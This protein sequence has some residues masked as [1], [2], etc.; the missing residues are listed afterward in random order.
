MQMRLFA[1]WSQ[2]IYFKWGCRTSFE[3]R[4]TLQGEIMPDDARNNG[5]RSPEHEFRENPIWSEPRH[6]AGSG[7]HTSD[8]RR[9]AKGQSQA[10]TLCVQGLSPVASAAVPGGR[11]LESGWGTCL[12]KG[13]ADREGR[14][15]PRQTARDYLRAPRA[16]LSH[17]PIIFSNGPWFGDRKVYR[18]F[19]DIGAVFSRSPDA[20]QH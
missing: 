1:S 3:N 16:P 5:N 6:S 13:G 8:G 15:V 11:G 17:D 19:G 2:S 7:W 10:F 4:F 14:R 18:H 9:D 20:F 12:R